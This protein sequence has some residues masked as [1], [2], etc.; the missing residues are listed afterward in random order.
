MVALDRETRRDHLERRQDAG[1]KDDHG[2]IHCELDGRDVWVC[3]TAR[4]RDHRDQQ[5]VQRTQDER[6]VD[7]VE[8]FCEHQARGE[9]EDVGPAPLCRR[10]ENA[11]RFYRIQVWQLVGS[12]NRAAVLTHE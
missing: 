5:A 6:H 9:I 2:E 7:Y 4:P 1:A 12:G 3:E 10:Q 8:R 11:Q